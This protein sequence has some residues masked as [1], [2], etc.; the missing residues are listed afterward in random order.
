MD[1]L[2]ITEDIYWVTP[3]QLQTYQLFEYSVMQAIVKLTV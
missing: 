3:T 1:L 2:I